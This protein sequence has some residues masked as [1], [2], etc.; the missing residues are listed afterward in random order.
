M[1]LL[2][3]QLWKEKIDALRNA[4]LNSCLPGAPEDDIQMIFLN[5]ID[6]LTPWHLRIMNLFDDPSRW[7]EENNTNFPESWLSGSSSQVLEFAYPEMAVN[8][9]LYLKLFNDLA[10]MGLAN[11]PTGMMTASGSLES[12]TTS[13]GKQFL[14]FIAFPS[15]LK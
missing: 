12:R 3:L 9:E 1:I 7:A 8:K 11:I 15:E 13:L 2:L 6:E 5:Y 4:V 14:R 10:T